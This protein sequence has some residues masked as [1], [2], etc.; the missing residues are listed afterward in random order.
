M[1]LLITF[2]I[3]LITLFLL[4]V[5]R[6]SKRPFGVS[7]VTAALGSISIL[8]SI[9]LWQMNL[10]YSPPAI[11]WNPTDVFHSPIAFQADTYSWLFSLS[12]GGL[13]CAVLLTSPIRTAN[14]FQ[15]S[16]WI[17]SIGFTGLG[18]L[19]VL[20]ANPLTLA[21]GWAAMDFAELINLFRLSD[22]PSASRSAISGFSFRITGTFLAIFAGVLMIPTG[23]E[24]SFQVGSSSLIALLFLF[25]AGLRLGVIPLHITLRTDPGQ[26]RGFGTIIR[27][28]TAASSMILIVR[29]A[30]TTLSQSLVF[31]LVPFVAATGI[32]SAW[33]WLTISGELQAR[34]FFIIAV[35][36]LSI[37][38]SIGG[39]ALG[40]AVWGVALVL[41]GGISFLYSA[42]KTNLSV[43]L[44]ATSILLIGLPFTFSASAWIGT[45]PISVLYTPLFILTELLVILGFVRH[46]FEH[47][48]IDWQQLP[49]WAQSVYPIGL[50]LLPSLAVVMSVWGWEGSQAFG[51]LFVSIASLVIFM[52]IGFLAWKGR[53]VLNS[54]INIKIDPFSSLFFKFTDAIGTGFQQL[55]EVL[56]ALFKTLSNLLEGDGGLLWTMVFIILILL[57]VR[58]S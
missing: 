10:P 7:W 5:F 33:N 14:G 51:N 26:R 38:A 42:H 9:F 24:N 45:L 57:S 37:G 1:Y 32:F 22:S 35:G 3:F 31:W 20:A 48:E 12:F 39:N 19:T 15:P 4:A 52:G 49:V 16:S 8:V 34:P 50:F 6:F 40:S 53:V 18:I 47:G 13:L 43:L 36:A 17:A 54:I 55:A 41:Y 23:Q 27:L 44:A 29:I 25:S 58:G 30:E 2:L 46:L 21:L 56:V 28:I 11:S